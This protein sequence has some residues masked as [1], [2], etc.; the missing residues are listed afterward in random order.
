MTNSVWRNDST[1]GTIRI[2]LPDPDHILIVAS[3]SEFF[4]VIPTTRDFS[5]TEILQRI[6]DGYAR[7]S[8]LLL[9]DERT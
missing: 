6:D 1:D 7:A 3:N 4:T 8:N 2:S 5:G 9:P